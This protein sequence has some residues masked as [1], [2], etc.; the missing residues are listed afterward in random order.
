MTRLQRRTAGWAALASIA[1]CV[2]TAAFFLLGAADAGNEV[3][4]IDAAVRLTHR[5]ADDSGGQAWEGESREYIQIFLA[6]TSPSRGGVDQLRSGNIRIYDAYY[7]PYPG[8][9]YGDR[10]EWSQFYVPHEYYE[11]GHPAEEG[12]FENLGGGFYR[13]NLLAYSDWEG[14][15]AVL[16]IEVE[17][18]WGR[19][20]TVCEVP[21]G[22]VWPLRESVGDFDWSW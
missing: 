22:M 16:Q 15:H 14:A 6:V 11:Y 1:A 17:C 5:L 20:I 2:A 9:E 3:L 10:S 8:P 19:G 4:D 7:S 12:D 18:P 21:L 13:I